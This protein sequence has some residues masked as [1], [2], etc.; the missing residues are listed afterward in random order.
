MKK[1]V[2][3]LTAGLVLATACV[4]FEAACLRS[5]TVYRSL[6]GCGHAALLVL[7]LLALVLLAAWLVARRRRAR[8]P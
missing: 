4:V 1:P 6:P 5:D 7:D 2:L 3:L 8:G